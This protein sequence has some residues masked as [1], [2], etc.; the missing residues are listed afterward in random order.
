MGIFRQ[1]DALFTTPTFSGH[2][3]GVFLAQKCDHEWRDDGEP[4][5][6]SVSMGGEKKP[7]IQAQKCAKCVGRRLKLMP[8]PGDTVEELGISYE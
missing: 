1:G 2:G 8:Q 4:A 6:S 5:V 3:D 7:S